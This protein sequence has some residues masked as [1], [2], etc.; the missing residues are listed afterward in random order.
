[1]KNK[2]FVVTN[3]KLVKDGTLCDAVNRACPF[4]DAIILREKDLSHQELLDLAQQVKKI[5]DSY[6]TPLIINNNLQVAGQIEA[7]G[8]HSGIKNYRQENVRTRLGLSIHTIEEALTAQKLG[9]DYIIAG[10]IFK[11]DCKPGLGG[12]GLSFVEAVTSSVSIPVIAIGGISTDN[13]SAVIKAGAHGIAVM[14]SA[15]EDADGSYLKSLRSRL[16]EI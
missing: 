1:M 10:N 15:M 5:T 11:T 8:Y 6:N 12:K 13:V 16:E 7:F 9:A 4:A 3:R 2:L 14:S